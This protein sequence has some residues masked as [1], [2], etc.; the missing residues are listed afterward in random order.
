MDN[1]NSWHSAQN[2]TN[3]L[4][5]RI[6]KQV[7]LNLSMPAYK[8]PLHF[9]IPPVRAARSILPVKV[10]IVSWVMARYT[11]AVITIQLQIR[12]HYN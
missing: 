2:G 10:T 12:V 5:P 11:V 8:L 3:S 4:L 7:P 9:D 1:A 6:S